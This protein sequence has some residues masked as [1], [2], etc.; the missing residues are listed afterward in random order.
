MTL[1][2][3]RLRPPPSAREAGPEL[4]LD[5]GATLRALRAEPHPPTH[6]HHQISIAHRGPLR[7]VLFAFDAG[8]R[9]P[10]HRAPGLVTILAL[11]GRLRIRTPRTVHE[12]DAGQA[13]LL[14]PEVPHDV[15]AP[16][17]SDM[18][19]AVHLLETR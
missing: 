4:S 16:V 14:D 13:V 15:D 8:G 17:E 2:D 18:L 3:D 12:L 19:L 7:L 1:A 10:E 11:R 6:G 9:L 5:L